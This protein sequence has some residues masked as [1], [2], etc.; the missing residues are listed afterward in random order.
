MQGMKRSSARLTATAASLAGLLALTGSVAT[1]DPVPDLP[2]LGGS[3]TTTSTAPPAPPPSVHRLFFSRSGAGA[4][5]DLW[6]VD[7][8]TVTS[9]DADGDAAPVAAANSADWD[10]SADVSRD[11]RSLVFVSDRDGDDEL[12]VLDLA[13][14]GARPVQ[15][16]SNSTAD[17]SPAWSPDGRSI[18]YVGW[19]PTG[20][21]TSAARVLVLTVDGG[22]TRVVSDP[23]PHQHATPAWSP[24]GSQLVYSAGYESDADLYVADAAS[25]QVLRR[26]TNGSSKQVDRSP[27]WAPDGSRIAFTRQE[28]AGRV[29]QM[30]IL[31]VA[32]EGGAPVPVVS[33]S[34]F[35][36]HPAWHPDGRSLAF[37]GLSQE[38]RQL[39]RVS[40]LATGGW[41][42]PARLLSSDGYDTQ[43]AW[44][45]VSSSSSTTP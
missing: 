5:P 38:V 34:T 45:L 35:A 37:S 36:E 29:R 22:A 44:G 2:I 41:S 1:A 21:R 39:Y 8:A 4:H 13:T 26:L 27:D 33:G 40:V 25:G 20:K 9:G 28:V 17:R 19:V 16:T 6:S 32:V 43:P 42:E 10:Y 31:V 12:Y 24:D 15:L 11:G 18:A 7:P 14:P 23:E 3:T 30:D